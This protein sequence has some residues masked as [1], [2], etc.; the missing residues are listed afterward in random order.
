[1]YFFFVGQHAGGG[2]GGCNVIVAPIITVEYITAV[3]CNMHHDG[4]L[5]Q[6]RHHYPGRGGVR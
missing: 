3:L 4:Q 2:S 6:Y 5:S 1:M